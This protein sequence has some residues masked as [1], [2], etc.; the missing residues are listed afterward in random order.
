MAEPARSDTEPETLSEPL[1]GEAKDSG[2]VVTVGGGV[3]LQ[4][5]FAKFREQKK[6][7]RRLMKACLAPGGRSQEYKDQLRAKFIEQAKKYMGVPYHEKYREEGTPVAPLY[8]DCC[9]LVRQCV[10]DLKTDFGFLIGRWN[11]V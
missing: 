10:K 9:G 6:T 4:E 3:S 5:A 11:Q 8:L 2:V 1:C 7:E